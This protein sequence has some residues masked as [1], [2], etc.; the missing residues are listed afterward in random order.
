MDERKSK[1]GI[2]FK[3]WY[4]TSRQE[5]GL[6]IGLVLLIVILSIASPLFLKF[7]NL[8]NIIRQVSIVAI[9]AIGGF[10]VIL[11]GGMDVSVGTLA[12][13]SGI[14]TAKLSIHLGVNII[15][16]VLVAMCV[17]LLVGVINGLLTTYIKLPSFIATL[18]TMQVCQ[19]VGYVI[20][21]ATPISGFDKGFVELG[22]GYLWEIPWLVIILVVLYVFMSLFMKYTRFGTY[23]YALGGNKEA[24]RLSGIR[25][26]KMQML[27]YICGGLF[28]ALGG[29]LVAARTNSGSAQVGSSYLFDVFTACVL[30]GTALSGGIGR[31]PGVLV[32]CIFVGILNNGMVQLNVDSFY[33]M[34]AQGVVLVLAVVLQAQLMRQKVKKKQAKNSAVSQN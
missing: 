2:S 21:Q 20:T 11:T 19:G 17:G 24:A 30:G 23:C 12:A 4:T 10:M 31:L 7:D 13:L 5:V 1:I 32:G 27:V 33:Q 3:N 22:R 18:G 29:I 15:L 16:A 8:L 14:V 26:N 28:S 9:I 25:V 6:Y 34:V